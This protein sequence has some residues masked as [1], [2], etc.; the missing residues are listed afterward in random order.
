MDFKDINE[1][2]DTVEGYFKPLDQY[3]WDWFLSLQNE[4]N[5]YGNL[6]E[7]GVFKGKSLCKLAQHKKGGEH[8]LGIDH[9]LNE[10]GM[11]T[12]VLNSIKK[13]SNISL[14]YVDLVP[15]QTEYID[16]TKVTHEDG[17]T[18]D[19]RNNTRFLHIDAGHSGYNAFEDLKLADQ[20]ISP[21]GILVMDDWR[22]ICYPD[23]SEAFYRYTLVNP[24]SYKIL[25]I[26]D[27]KMYACRPKE[28]ANYLWRIDTKLIPFLKEHYNGD[29]RVFKT[30]NF[31]D[32]GKFVI[33]HKDT[34]NSDIDPRD[35][36]IDLVV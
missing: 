8:V 9:L 28:H 26:T 13:T 34:V 24:N 4:E 18:T 11:K 16:S 17:L 22:T 25:M 21:N 12:T 10:E 7:F 30:K 27:S 6:A 3:T 5:V 1:K 23:I 36:A 32:V 33:T 14:S 35:S 15:K 31:V 2:I 29:L 20:F 19:Y